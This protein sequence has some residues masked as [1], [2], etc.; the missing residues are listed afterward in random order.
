MSDVTTILRPENGLGPARPTMV[1]QLT[2]VPL[3]RGD[4]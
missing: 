2:V 4:A 1:R 3:R